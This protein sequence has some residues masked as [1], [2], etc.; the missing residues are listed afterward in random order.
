MSYT[1]YLSKTNARGQISFP[2]L[3]VETN[4][5]P[6]GTLLADYWF[7]ESAISHLM[8]NV[9]TL[10]DATATDPVQ[11]K[12]MKDIIRNHWADAFSYLGTSMLHTDFR[13]TDEQLEQAT[14][15]SLK[16]A[17]GA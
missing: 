2:T 7:I 10:I 1:H 9:M 15:V 16:D 6:H 4:N 13:L 3:P 5:S 14:E 11:K 12:A 8:G 17:L